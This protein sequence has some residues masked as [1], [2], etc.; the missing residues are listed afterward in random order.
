MHELKTWP[1]YFERIADGTKTFEMRRNDRGFQ[2]GDLLI[3]REF[4]PKSQAYTGRVIHREV[5][6]VLSDSPLCPLGP[7]VV[8]SLLPVSAGGA[9]GD[10]AAEASSVVR[11][12]GFQTQ[13]DEARRTAGGDR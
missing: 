13:L 8:M 12:T 7:Y 5:G 2:R 3:L 1:E 11:R 10:R 4:K 6:F 9:A